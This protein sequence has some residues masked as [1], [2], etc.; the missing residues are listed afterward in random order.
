MSIL[1][2]WAVVIHHAEA[3]VGNDPEAA[4]DKDLCLDGFLQVD[5]G[6]RLGHFPALGPVLSAKEA[7][8]GGDR[9]LIDFGYDGGK[10]WVV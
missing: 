2:G 6:L 5:P 10:G 1:I 8:V 4:H 9:G 7:G 3:S